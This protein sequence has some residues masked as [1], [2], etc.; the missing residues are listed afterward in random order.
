MT[1]SLRNP[2]GLQRRD[3]PRVDRAF[4]I[5]AMLMAMAVVLAGCAGYR[6]GPTNGLMAGQ[7]SIQVNPFQNQTIEPRLVEYTT[8]ALRKR[9][10]QDGTFRL[11]T[12]QDGDII[13]NGVIVEFR[14]S[15]L[16]FQPSDIRTVRDYTVALRA[17]I[18]AVER[19]TGRTILDR[20]AYARTTL[21]VGA[22]LASAERQAVPL[23]A[24][25]LARNVTSLLV[26]GTW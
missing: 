15:E 7:R 16:S 13:V 21:R 9:L 6:V 8:T 5:A 23:L 1:S 25:D 11:A 12:Q 18:K 24:E 4:R 2:P 14:R 19:S 26:D 20:P 10:Q 22:D 17:Q 3:R